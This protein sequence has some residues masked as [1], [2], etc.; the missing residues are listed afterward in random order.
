MCSVFMHMHDSYFCCKVKD[1]AIC[2]S[3]GELFLDE[4]LTHGTI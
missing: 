3:Q 1:S 4:I 2:Y